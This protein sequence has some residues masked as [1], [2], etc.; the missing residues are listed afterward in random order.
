MVVAVFCFSLS[1][2]LVRWAAG[3]SAAEIAAARL[4][5]AG[6]AVLALAWA[7][8]DA[9]PPRADWPRF[10][11]Y[12]LITALHF[13]LYI[14]ALSFTTIAHTLALVYTA[15]IFVAL[16]SWLLLGEGLRA[17]QWLGTLVTIGGVVLLAGLE[18]QLDRRMVTGD[19]M[20]LGSAVCFG[21]YSVAGRSGR[22]RYS[23]FGYAGTVYAFGALWLLPLALASFSPAGYTWRAVGSVLALGLVPLGLGHTLYNAALRRTNATLVNL[24][25][26][27]EVTAG[28][29]LG[30][31]FLNEIPNLTTVVGVLVALAGIVLVIL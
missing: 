19:L 17:R 20:A 6:V 27:Q 9:L 18:P 29:I 31:I 30:I 12:G 2:V 7:R 1:A 24:V 15:P 4:L 23:L 11:L 16:F 28:I 10:A 3:L 26:T 5:I 22:A 8:R 25:A 21:L 13:G 14:A